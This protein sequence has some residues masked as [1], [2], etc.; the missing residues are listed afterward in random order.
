MME[1]FLQAL[2]PVD[3]ALF[4]ALASPAQVQ[5][6]L[7]SL[8][9][10]GEERNRSPLAVMQDR[11]CHCLD[12]AL[13]AALALSQMGFSA[14]IIALVPEPYTDDDHVLAIYRVA[15]CYGAVAKSNFSGLRFRE[16]IYRSLR[17]LAMSYFEVFFNQAGLKTLR[18]YTRPL[19]LAG[20]ADIPWQVSDEGVAM[21]TRRLYALKPVALLN[22]A[23]IARLSPM[24]AR[25]YQTNMLDVDLDG[26]YKGPTA[27]R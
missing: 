15:G 14:R 27:P 11:Q 16:P 19:D 6:Y 12:G 25:A 13:L 10:V 24:D 2:D 26:L 5:D 21:V 23:Q 1:V 7:D 20:F 3:Q 8:P 9:Y 22:A 17:E 4:Q 18:G